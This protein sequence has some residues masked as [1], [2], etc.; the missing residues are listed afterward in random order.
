MLGFN[1]IRNS[2]ET[3]ILNEKKY[4]IYH[5]LHMYLSSLSFAMLPESLGSEFINIALYSFLS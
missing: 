2:P 1:Y 5:F 3:N 4:F